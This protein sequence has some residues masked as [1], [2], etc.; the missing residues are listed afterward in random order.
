LKPPF[1]TLVRSA[2]LSNRRPHLF[3]SRHRVLLVAMAV[4]AVLLSVFISDP[5]AEAVAPSF[6]AK[7]DF[8]TGLFP[9]SITVGDL[10]GDGLPDLAVANQAQG[11]VSVLLNTTAPGAV[12]PNFA[13]KQNFTTGNTPVSVALGDVNGDG[14]L[15]LIVAS[16]GFGGVSVLLN[17]TAPGAALPSFDTAQNF[18]TG[19]TPASVAFGDLNGDGLLDLAVANNA[20]TNVSVLLNIAAP[21]A[22]TP[23]FAAK[24]DFATGGGPLSVAI[25]DLNGDGNRDLAVANS[26]AATSLIAKPIEV[27][28]AVHRFRLRSSE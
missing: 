26:G 24:Q 19:T 21:G 27:K 1:R 13:A 28:L 8:A 2:R 20:S 17:T 25:G 16:V 9:Y 11:N 14:K 7:Q 15:D 3:V 10:N 4:S 22:A 18:L 23:N 12:T 5:V 6:A